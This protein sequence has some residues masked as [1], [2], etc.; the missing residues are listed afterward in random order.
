MKSNG[1]FF[2]RGLLIWVALVSGI[3][4]VARANFLDDIGDFFTGNAPEV[5][6]SQGCDTYAKIAVLWANA[7]QRDRCPLTGPRYG[8]D[9]KLHYEWCMGVTPET[10]TGEGNARF[11]EVSAC[12]DDSTLNYC[13][14]YG[15]IAAKDAHDNKLYNCG[16]TGPRWGE[17]SEGHRSYCLSEKIAQS[18]R[19]EISNW[20]GP[21]LTA[22]GDAVDQCKSKH[23]KKQ[24][25][26]C[27]SYATQAVANAKIFT[28]K[29]CDRS[30]NTW[31]RWDTD[32]DH[33]FSWCIGT[34]PFTSNRQN[35]ETEIRNAAVAECV[36]QRNRPPSGMVKS[37]DEFIK[38]APS[39][40]LTK[41]TPKGNSGPSSSGAYLSKPIDGNSAMDRLTGGGGAAGGSSS[42]ISTSRS[43]PRPSGG[44]SSGI[45]TSKPISPPSGG[46]SS[47]VN[48]S[49]PI[50]PPSGGSSSGIN[51]SR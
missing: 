19:G 1:R 43:G 14:S 36:A 37:L 16:F 46:S 48:L 18:L 38:A 31:G 41:P 45:S 2:H 13:T 8:T 34:G 6:T 33:H 26:F 24:V 30:Q 47:G 49:A 22:R 44:G 28:E 51:L 29:R 25:Q 50:S 39:N 17:G 5:A 11:R 4:G 12:N 23:S 40:P 10:S 21:E 35:S 32:Y 3:A 20:P 9:E 42:G 15:D 27:D 7:A